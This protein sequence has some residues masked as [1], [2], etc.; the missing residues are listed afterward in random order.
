MDQQL[1]ISRLREE[2]ERHNHLYFIEAQPEIND[3][4][5]DQLMQTLRQ[6]ESENPHLRSHNKSTKVHKVYI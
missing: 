4:D 3:H 5:F 6:L 1:A 2:I